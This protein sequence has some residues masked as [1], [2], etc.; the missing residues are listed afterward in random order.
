[1]AQSDIDICSAAFVLLGANP[2]Q[3][4]DDGSYEAEVATA[5]YPLIRD[6]MLSLHPWSFATG[7]VSLPTLTDK[8]VASFAYAHQL[9]SDFL[10]AISVGVSPDSVGTPYRI[11][12]KRIHAD[13]TPIVLRYVFRPD[14][15]SWP[16]Y[17][18]MCLTQHLKAHFAVPITDRRTLS[19]FSFQIDE[20]SFARAKN[21]DSQQQTPAAIEVSLDGWR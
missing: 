5:L 1:M 7:E 4:F 3:S 2:I 17:F 12:E 19:E 15:S 21:M 10:R 6:S 11:A 9:P 8:P 14:E 13:V 16:P 18:D 20:A